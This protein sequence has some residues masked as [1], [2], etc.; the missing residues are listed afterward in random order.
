M[1]IKHLIENENYIVVCDTNVYLNIY[2]YS[3]EFSEFA[4]QCMQ[5]VQTSIILP[6]TVRLEYLKHY[7]SEFGS[8]KKKVKTAGTETKNQIESSKRKVINTC[9]TLKSLHYPDIADLIDSLENKFSELETLLDRFFEDRNILGLISDSWGN[10]D[11]VFELVEQITK[12]NQIMPPVTQE[13]IYRI[14]EEGEK[15][16]KAKPPI[17]PGFKD[18]KNKDGIRKYS[19]LI[20]WKEVIQ[21][22]KDSQKNII[23]VTDDV[24]LDWWLQD[25]YERH[26]HPELIKEFNCETSQKI[27]SYCSSDFFTELSK[28]YHIEQSDAFE[29]A[30]RITDSDYF[31]RVNEQVFD[32]VLDKLSLSG[33]EYI[34]TFS[35]HVGT[36]GF[37]ELEITNHEFLSAE[38]VERDEDNIIYVFK[39]KVT[40]EATSFDYCGRDDDSKEIILSPG[41][42][43]QFE[44]TINVEVIREADFFLDFEYDDGFEIAKIIEG[45]LVE[46][47]YQ[48]YLEEEEPVEGAYTSCPDCGCQI[49][50]ENDGGNGYC[51]NCAAE[52]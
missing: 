51:A 11:L 35:A 44:G 36:E 32:K 15:R 17:P 22:A 50:F 29:I 40:A 18:A 47:D 46:T 49:N 19:D 9:D 52:H 1:D 30:L 41:A 28:A 48:I 26:F 45:N 20:L 38:Q 4:M 37:D 31:S 10:V 23:F 39:Y 3:P 13:N 27:I 21:Y 5:A 7:R 14:C 8:I 2:R 12:A 6:S 24:K 43:H 16:Y 42:F 33:E 34:E 25:N